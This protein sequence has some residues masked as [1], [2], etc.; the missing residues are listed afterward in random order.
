MLFLIKEAIGSKVFKK[1]LKEGARFE[2]KPLPS[3]PT[4][5]DGAVLL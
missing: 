3:K 4:G 5:L 2:V 1:K